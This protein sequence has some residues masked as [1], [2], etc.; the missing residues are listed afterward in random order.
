[1]IVNHSRE[2]VF[3]HIPKTAGTSVQ[4][5]L[6]SFPGSRIANRGTKHWT[7]NDLL[8]SRR[9]Q[10]LDGYVFFAFVRNP[11]DRFLSLHRYLSTKPKFRS[12]VPDQFATFVTLLANREPWLMRLHSIRLQLDFVA[13]TECKIGRYESLVEDFAAIT[14][15]FELKLELPR[16]NGS[17][18]RKVDYRQF[19][20]DVDAEIIG[21]EYEADLKQFGYTFD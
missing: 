21:R 1:M 16:L 2:L 9:H 13:G 3:I 12:R 19:Y 6:L 14:A 20:S 18:K 4:N 11:W 5:A 10:S 7:A 17:A 15:S 8:R